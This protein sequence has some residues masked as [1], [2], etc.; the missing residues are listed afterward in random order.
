MRLK[1]N[2]EL[3]PAICCCPVLYRIDQLFPHESAGFQQIAIA[4]AGI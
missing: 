4:I 3:R 1:V 2:D